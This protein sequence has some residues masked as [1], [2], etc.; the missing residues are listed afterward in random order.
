MRR[1]LYNTA[2]SAAFPFSA[3][4]GQGPECS[5][6]SSVLSACDAMSCTMQIGY[7]T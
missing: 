3:L 2:V 4:Q 6:Q 1:T 5:G 7:G